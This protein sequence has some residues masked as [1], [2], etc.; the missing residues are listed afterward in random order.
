MV[1]FLYSFYNNP[2]QKE[3]LTEALWVSK[4]YSITSVLTGLGLPD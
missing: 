3:E 2:F 1:A 4:D